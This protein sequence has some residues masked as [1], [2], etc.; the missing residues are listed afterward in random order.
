MGL[1]FML[2][3]QSSFAVDQ[4]SDSLGGPSSVAGGKNSLVVNRSN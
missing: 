2:T 3:W 4:F 1:T